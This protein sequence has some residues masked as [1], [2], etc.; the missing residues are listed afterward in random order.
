[1]TMYS[2]KKKRK[3]YYPTV[4]FLTKIIHLLYTETIALLIDGFRGHAYDFISQNDI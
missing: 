2:C 4:F 3:S 1:M